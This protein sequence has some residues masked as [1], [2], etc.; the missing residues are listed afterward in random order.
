MGPVPSLSVSALQELRRIY[1]KHLL[2]VFAS[3][4]TQ[5]LYERGCISGRFAEGDG[6]RAFIVEEVTPLGVAVLDKLEATSST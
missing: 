3:S 6:R 4:E 1:C 2:E 5:E